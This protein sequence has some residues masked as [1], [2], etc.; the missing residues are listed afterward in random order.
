MNLLNLIS[1][2][3][4]YFDI[5]KKEWLE[6]SD[7][8]PDF[9]HEFRAETKKQNQLFIQN[10]SQTLGKQL[11]RFHKLPFQKKHWKSKTYSLIKDL[12]WNEN[13]FSIHQHMSN[14]EI[15][16]FQKEIEYFL[17]EVRSF[18]P[19]LNF[20]DIG[21]AARN[22]IV[23]AMFKK[24]HND[25]S[26][27]SE[28]AFGYSM[29]YPF[30]DNY[31]DSKTHSSSDKASYNRLIF[32]QIKGLKPKAQTSHQ[33][34]TCALIEAIETQYPRNDH[35]E[36]YDLLLMML[37]AQSCSLSQQQKD[38]PLS[39][40]DRLNISIYKGG[41]SVLI[42]RYFVHKELSEKDI[43]FYLGFGLVL[44][45]ADDLQDIN[46]DD[47]KGHSTLMTID[48]DA[49]SEERIVNKLLHY[50]HHIMEAYAPENMDFMNFVLSSSYLL[51]LT[52]VIGSKEFFSESYLRKINRYLPVESSFLEQLLNNRIENSVSKVQK[53]YM[54]QLDDLLNK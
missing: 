1:N 9:L 6:S 16:E 45:L 32:E 24:I 42:D 18:A 11:K 37:D 7:S 33:Q 25:S 53:K 40:E 46:E 19:E 12:L 8:F 26:G 5:I 17:T 35:P 44:Q 41:I 49:V 34:K 14:S 52:S 23:F 50:L 13:V 38:T 36:I 27:Y 48:T 2:Q 31:I 20:N 10:S 29:L 43:L 28:A 3:H 30:T 22:Y 54:K 4:D 39:K 47:T 15:Q 21:Q 51:I